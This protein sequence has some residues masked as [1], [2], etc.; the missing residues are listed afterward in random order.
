MVRQNEIHLPYKNSTSLGKNSSINLGN[1]KDPNG[2]YI[3][4]SGYPW[5][6]SIIHDFKVPKESVKIHNAYN[7]FKSWAISGGLE[8]KDWY[9]DN[10][11]NRNQNLLEN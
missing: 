1:N 3:S 11:G 8:F 10:P 5:A 7:Y 9:K 4:S 2:N 6:I